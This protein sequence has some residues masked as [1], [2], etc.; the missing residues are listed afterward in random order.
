ML[1]FIDLPEAAKRYICIKALRLFQ[2]R[3]LGSQVL[4]QFQRDDEAKAR[5]QMLGE[6]RKQA[7]PNILT[8]TY[9]PTGTWRIQD[10][11]NNRKFNRYD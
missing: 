2:E 9:P 11:S 1:D 10:M 4:S 8:A 5:V 3:V 7:R 6:E